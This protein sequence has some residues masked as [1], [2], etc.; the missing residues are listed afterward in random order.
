MV[1]KSIEDIKKI[2]SE[3]VISDEREMIIR[4]E[5]EKQWE[6]IR[7]RFRFD[8][9]QNGSHWFRQSMGVSHGG[10][11]GQGLLFEDEGFVSA[12]SF[13]ATKNERGITATEYGCA[14]FYLSQVWIHGEKLSHWLSRYY[15]KQM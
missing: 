2:A 6:S 12:A 8:W 3:I 5:N 10:F 7:L 14:A 11:D 4:N 1:M 9:R 15:P 13:H